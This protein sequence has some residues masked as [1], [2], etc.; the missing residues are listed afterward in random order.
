ML[1][2]WQEKIEQDQRAAFVVAAILA[3]CIYGALEKTY[4]KEEIETFKRWFASGVLFAMAIPYV[5]QSVIKIMKIIRRVRKMSQGNLV[6][7]LLQMD[8]AEVEVMPTAEVEIKRL[9]E[10]LGVPFI[11]KCRAIRGD[12]YADIQKMGVSYSRK[13]N[14]K[15][16]NFAQTK[17]L[18]I[19]DGVVEPDFKNQDLL[20]KF[21]ALTPKDL[22]YKLFLP[23]ELDEIY[24]KITE[25]CGYD[26]EDESETDEEIKN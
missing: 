26:N 16:L 11:V 23:G 1:R 21:T 10:K 15:D 13:G 2:K 3:I 9:S 20:K 4:G 7:K 12:R 8:V 19:L 17:A 5:V 6:D 25:L 24:S 18:V 14:F 22:I